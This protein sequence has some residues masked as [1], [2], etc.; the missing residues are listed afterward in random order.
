VAEFEK[1][2]KPSNL[3][4]VV[5]MAE[6]FAKQWQYPYLRVDFMLADPGARLYFTEFAISP[7]A[8]AVDYS[9]DLFDLAMAGV[10]QD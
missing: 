3:A 6:D 9:T 4:D 7:D 10:T 5:G 2:M 1:G 8:C